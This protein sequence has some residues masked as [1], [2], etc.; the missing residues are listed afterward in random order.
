MHKEKKSYAKFFAVFNVLA[1][2]LIA[3]ILIYWLFFNDEAFE[4]SR[5]LVRENTDLKIENSALREEVERLTDLTER[6]AQQQNESTELQE[7]ESDINV[8]Q[9]E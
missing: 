4:K 7:E 6:S 3:A 2:M 5:S 1:V 9:T 8:Y